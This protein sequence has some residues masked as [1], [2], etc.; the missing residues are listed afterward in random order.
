MKVNKIFDKMNFCSL[1]N[2]N[3]LRKGYKRNL[4]PPLLFV[5]ILNKKGESIT[6]KFRKIYN[7]M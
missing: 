7:H 6:K 4:T 3:W 1:C 2:Y 5:L